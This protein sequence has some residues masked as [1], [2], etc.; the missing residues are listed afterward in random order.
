MNAQLSNA[1]W[2]FSNAAWLWTGLIGLIVAVV[3][4]IARYRGD[5]WRALSTPAALL[6]IAF[7]VASCWF[8]LVVLQIVQPTWLPGADDDQKRL[9]LILISGFGAIAIFRSSLF[10]IKG[11]DGDLA[12]GPSIIID[13]L[14]AASDRGVDRAVATMRGIK[15]AKLMAD[16]SFDRAKIALPTYCFALMQNVGEDEQKVIGDQIDALSKKVVADRIRTLNLGLLLVNIVGERVLAGAVKD[17]GALLKGDPPIEQREVAKVADLMADVD[18]D[19]AR[20]SLPTYC[21]SLATDVSKEAQAALGEQVSAL[22]NSN[23]PERVRLLTFG[24]ALWGTVGFDVLR[25]A[26]GQ[27]RQSISADPAPPRSDTLLPRPTPAPT[28]A[29]AKEEAANAAP[30]P[31]VAPPAPAPAPAPTVAAA[32][33]PVPAPAPAP[34]APPAPVRQPAPPAASAPAPA[35]K[36]TLPVATAPGM[37]FGHPTEAKSAPVVQPQPEPKTPVAQPETKASSISQPD[38]KASVAGNQPATKASEP[39]AESV[40]AAAQQTPTKTASSSEPSL[41]EPTEINSTSGGK[42][43]RRPARS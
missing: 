22:A 1:T 18:F 42:S 27:L 36:P 7:N 40:T 37:P 31:P 15:V 17:L 4:L 34:L 20:L 11:P 24:L 8:I 9:Y 3:E 35:P 38:A 2:L 13:T 16:I 25:L 26:V 39:A 29:P 43:G 14:L 19:K 21:L 12:I 10:R 6:Y 33:A 23:L 5:P 32:P 41:L 30:L 28:P